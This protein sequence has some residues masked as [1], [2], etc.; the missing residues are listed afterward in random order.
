MPTTPQ[1]KTDEFIEKIV[2]ASIRRHAMDLDLWAHTKLWQ[3]AAAGCRDDLSTRCP[4]LPRELPIL[5]SYRD[6]EHWTFVTTRRIWH[7]DGGPAEALSIS[8]VRDHTAGNFKGHAGQAWERMTITLWDDSV[9]KCPYETGK[10]SMGIVY[11][12]RTLLQLRAKA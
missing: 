12:V 6:R 7:C 3:D 5:Y 11:A 1:V 9:H 4:L 8:D 10:P 2:V